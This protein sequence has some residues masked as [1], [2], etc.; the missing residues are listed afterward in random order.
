MINQW[1]KS[2]SLLEMGLGTSKLFSFKAL[3]IWKC[4]FVQQAK[5]LSRCGRDKP[6]V[7]N[8]SRAKEMC[9]LP[10]DRGSC[11]LAW[12]WSQSDNNQKTIKKG[13]T[14]YKNLD[15]LLN[16]AATLSVGV[17]AARVGA[18][19]RSCGEDVGATRTTFPH[20]KSV[21]ENVLISV[22]DDKTICVL[23]LVLKWNV[24]KTY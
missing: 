23:L 22:C 2:Q 20:K 15:E 4:I 18:A 12:A 6:V 21:F 19:E 7:K 5:C 17:E 13:H 8:N 9:S 3:K 14:D 24:F 16:P 11:R 10:L 1:S